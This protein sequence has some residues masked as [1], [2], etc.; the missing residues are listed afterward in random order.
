MQ[1]PFDGA[2]ALQAEVLLAKHPLRSSY[3]NDA[4]REA[5]RHNCNELHLASRFSPAANGNLSQR[6]TKYSQLV[7]IATESSYPRLQRHATMLHIVFSARHG[8]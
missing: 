7:E 2:R 3:D 5:E 6:S 8:R 4:I 1:W